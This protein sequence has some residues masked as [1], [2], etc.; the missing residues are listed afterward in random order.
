MYNMRKKI[1]IIS[2]E[3]SG[4]IYGAR[5][6]N[7]LRKQSSDVDISIMG[8]KRMI[9]TNAEVMVDST[10]LGVVGFLEVLG[11]FFTFIKIF[12]NMVKRAAHERPDCV[13]LIDYPGFNLRLAAKLQ[14]LGI[15]VIWYI[16]PQ[17]WAWKKGRIAKLATYCR[18]MLVIFPFEPEVYAGSGLDAEFVGHPL[19]DVVRER[20]DSKI[21]RDDNLMLLLP[22]SRSNEI[23]RLFLPMLETVMR[24]KKTH[25]NLHFLVAAPRKTVSDRLATILAE[26]K[27]S[28][29]EAEELSINIEYGKTGEFLQKAC[30]GLAASGTVTVECAIAG[31]P[32]TVVYI[33]NP[34]TFFIAKML[35]NI[36]FFT[37]ANIIAGKLLYEEYLQ[38]D[39]NPANLADSME[40]ILPGGERREEVLAGLR[41]VRKSLSVKGCDG[42]AKAAE[43]ILKLV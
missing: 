42:S 24:L 38:G 17:V 3:E 31:L 18:K 21:E 23:N 2:G 1:W 34:I 29:P 22:G 13:V 40:R 8:G 39:V 33:L 12:R 27:A 16:S 19:V 20:S 43:A 30:A 11:M 32:L 28:H 15:P 4:D 35:V 41:E 5:L 25:P 9:A 36:P 37:M 6:I 26:F 14:L 10:E 7:E